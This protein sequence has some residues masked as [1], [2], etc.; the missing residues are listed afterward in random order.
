[1]NNSSRNKSNVFFSDLSPFKVLVE[2]LSHIPGLRVLFGVVAVLSIIA[3]TRVWSLDRG[4]TI[5][6]GIAVV[7]FAFVL[8]VLAKFST[9]KASIFRKPATVLMWFCVILFIVWCGLLTSCVFF[10]W[11][12]SVKMLPLSPTSA[13]KTP[14]IISGNITIDD[15]PA[16]FLRD[17]KL[18]CDT[19][20]G[21]SLEPA[22]LAGARFRISIPAGTS[23]A[24]V[25]ARAGNRLGK[26]VFE[27]L[28]N[29]HQKTITIEPIKT[30]LPLLRVY[31]ERSIGPLDKVF[32]KAGDT[33]PISYA[34][35]QP[36]VLPK[37]TTFTTVITSSTSIS[38]FDL[39]ATTDPVFVDNAVVR[40]THWSPPPSIENI[41]TVNPAASMHVSYIQIDTPNRSGKT[42]FKAPFLSDSGPIYLSLRPDEPERL[43]IITGATTPGVYTFDVGIESHSRDHREIVWAISGIRVYFAGPEIRN[44]F[45]SSDAEITKDQNIEELIKSNPAQVLLPKN[46]ASPSDIARA[47]GLLTAPDTEAFA[48]A[49]TLYD[50]HRFDNWSPLNRQIIECISRTGGDESIPF[51]E[52]LLK[53]EKWIEPEAA[54]FSLL[55]MN[56]PAA[57]GVL[58]SV[59]S[60]ETNSSVESALVEAAAI[61]LPHHDLQ[62]LVLPLVYKQLSSASEYD[63]KYALHA[64][65]RLRPNE[66]VSTAKDWL[67]SQDDTKILSAAEVCVLLDAEGCFDLI[68]TSFDKLQ[69]SYHKSDLMRSLCTLAKENDIPVLIGRLR[70]VEDADSANLI[71]NAL[72]RLTGEHMGFIHQTYFDDPEAA[73]KN[74]V[75][76]ARWERWLSKR[77]GHE[78]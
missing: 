42:L 31:A 4:W 47:I 10:N 50:S 46:D 39:E 3:I 14:T 58:K 48:A 73:N 27:I 33:I 18:T 53:S 66:A 64:L 34:R 49:K 25:T 72:S 77:R 5:V 26:A 1:M 41:L 6:G 36:Q 38:A 37:I 74:D 29:E 19:D 68:N 61:Q 55:Q 69:A 54:V 40:V 7:F 2:A 45:A 67:I 43:A 71:V 16:T 30:G 12:V 35:T 51:L 75:V 24:T 60:N 70:A 20:T 63:Q 59:L 15:R 44:V 56:T 76:I 23:S 52:N 22:I 57:I 32:T 11:P 8:L 62:P 21:L 28:K 17:L 65:A 78:L 9:S 13:P